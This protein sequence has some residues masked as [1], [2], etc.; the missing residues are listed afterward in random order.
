MLLGLIAHLL[1]AVI[2]A[3]PVLAL[4]SQDTLYDYTNRTL[5]IHLYDDHDEPNKIFRLPFNDEYTSGTDI[6]H[7]I[8]QPPPDIQ[9]Q[10]IIADS[11]LYSFCPNNETSNT[12]VY[13]YTHLTDSWNQLSL[14]SSIPFYDQSNY[15]YTDS[16]KT[17]IYIF[18]GYK[19]ST[20]VSDRML[21]LDLT[22]L[23]TSDAST[24]I[25]PSP[26]YDSSAVQINE[27]TQAL[28]GGIIE[29]DE[30]LNMMEIP[31]W[32]YN[33]WAERPCIT[34][35]VRAIDP[36]IGAIMLPIFDLYN[37][38]VVNETTTSFQ[39]SSVLM[40]GGKDKNGI[41]AY[42]QIASLNVSANVWIWNDLTDTVTKSNAQA[43]VSS[44]ALLPDESLAVGTIYNTLIKISSTDSANYTINL[45]NSTSFDH[46]SRVDYTYLNNIQSPKMPSH[47]NKGTIIAISVIIPVLMIIILI[48]LAYW[49][50]RKY[51]IKRE[52]EIN[53]REIKEIVDFY[54]NQH[55]QHSDLTFTSSSDSDYKS[56]EFDF[57]YDD[58]KINNYDDGD[59]L[60][61][62]SWRQ[63]R[64]EFER[65]QRFFGMRTNMAL[66]PRHNTN[67]LMRSLSV[68]SNFLSSQLTRK[69]STQ[70]SI[71][72]FITAKTT[73]SPTCVDEQP[74]NDNPFFDEAVSIHSTKSMSTLDVPPP[75]VP[76]HST[77]LTRPQRANSFLNY[78]PENDS[79]STF[80]S[81]GLG[82]IPVS[83]LQHAENA[84]VKSSQAQ[85]MM[86]VYKPTSSTVTKRASLSSL[87]SF[88]SSNA[89]SSVYPVS[90]LASP[91]K[92]MSRSHSRSPHKSSKRPSSMISSSSSTHS[93][94]RYSNPPSSRITYLSDIHTLPE[95]ENETDS[96]SISGADL[97]N[98]EVQ[99]LVSS[100][101]RSKLRVVNP[102]DSVSTDEEIE[103]KLIN[104]DLIPPFQEEGEKMRCSSTSSDGKNNGNDDCDTETN[105]VRKRV[106]SGEHHDESFCEL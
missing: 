90:T 98:M 40:V 26:F 27:N 2:S 53:E 67:S 59:N 43:S 70:S 38:Y 52:E 48:S 10:L 4:S 94:R 15:I 8:I 102:D 82:S 33:S 88:S 91:K 34:T 78:I 24:R 12:D 28:F 80:H 47:T 103:D 20:T 13:K 50:V 62:S 23:A 3:S 97:V 65:Q 36:R 5:Y 16:D 41:N 61:I 72:T 64:R 31:L 25:Q 35:S 37:A 95:H 81:D 29:D 93:S 84:M 7:S 92:S 9:C 76:R 66:L 63:K 104:T 58:I 21:R 19:N 96:G 51:R 79:V 46:L 42:P 71:A 106:I 69:N 54:E 22:S 30:L 101:R 11:F 105:N 6:S 60:S 73:S 99:V 86:Q 83:S 74:V 75:V 18:S 1:L 32:Q 49:L 55:K 39:V 56:A 14:S 68:A 44:S 17:G 89:G 100:K 77:L 45:F 87:G 85:Y 57:A